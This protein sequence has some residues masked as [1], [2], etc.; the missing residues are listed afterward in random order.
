MTMPL[1]VAKRTLL[2]ACAGTIL[3]VASAREASPKERNAN[4]YAARF[5]FGDA[6]VTVVSDGLI[7]VGDPTKSFRGAPPQEIAATLSGSFL[8]TDKIVFDENVVVVETGTDVILFDT[9]CGPITVFGPRA[10]KLPGN[11]RT[12]G[13]EPSEITAVVLSHGHADHIGGLVA[14]EQLVFQNAQYYMSPVDHAFWLDPARA[15]SPLKFFHEQ[16]LIYLTPLRDR[17]TFIQDGQE[18]LPGIQATAA[19]GHTP[20]HMVFTVSSAGRTLAILADLARQHILNVET[21]QLEFIG[22][23]DPRLTVETRR[24]LFDLYVRDAT[25]VLSYHFPF[26]GV[27]HLA[28][29]GDA[30]RYY[31]TN[32][33]NGI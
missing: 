19:P 13:I 24:R 22:D 33:H 21:P 28:R 29:R 16:A 14:N 6:Q 30:Y 27:G 9:G 10:G 12:A 3:T 7:V 1:S 31:P 20:G 4:T 18:F 32:L 15:A 8:A 11:L 26:P 17:L 25:P 2:G 23:I 5:R